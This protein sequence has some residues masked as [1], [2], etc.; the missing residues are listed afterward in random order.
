MNRQTLSLLLWPAL[1]VSITACGP[2]P[3]QTDISQPSQPKPAVEV[4]QATE[5]IESVSDTPAVQETLVE[6]MDVADAVS[7]SLGEDFGGSALLDF[8][9]ADEAMTAGTEFMHAGDYAKALEQF[10]VAADI[11][12]E[13]EEVFFNLGFAHS[14]LGN[15][16]EA[17]AAYQKTIEIFPDYGEAHNNLGN[18]FLK[19]KSF[20]K[21]IEHFKS[22][23]EIDP[24]HAAAHN[25]L[26]TALS[27]QSKI[28]EAVPHFAKATQLDEAYIQAWCNLGNAYIVQSRFEDAIGAFQ[29]AL[30]IN[31]DFRPALAGMQRIRSKVGVKPR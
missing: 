27:R 10:K 13:N 11:D 17:V 21:A 8:A 12:T 31:P 22:A 6:E 7:D 24:D 23:L 15:E 4:S 29:Q 2:Q 26:G 30:R 5:K 3:K 14:R 16:E 28:S 25:N 19:Q 9:K 18:L 20:S 1:V